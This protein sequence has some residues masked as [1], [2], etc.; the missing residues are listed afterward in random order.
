MCAAAMRV[1]V[2]VTCGDGNAPVRFNENRKK[3]KTLAEGKTDNN[4]KLWCGVHS[5]STMRR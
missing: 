3:T 1:F 4:C 5:S 2:C